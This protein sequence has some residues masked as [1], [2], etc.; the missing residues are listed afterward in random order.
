M[1]RRMHLIEDSNQ[2]QQKR[3]EEFYKKVQNVP[4]QDE[5]YM[6]LYQHWADQAFSNLFAVIA[7]QKLK[8]FQ[9]PVH[10]EFGECSSQAKTVPMHA[11]CLSDLMNGKFDG[12][13]FY[14]AAA[15]KAMRFDKYR[16]KKRGEFRRRHQIK[17]Q[18][19]K[20][21]QNDAW[22]GSFRM[23]MDMPPIP[24]T[25][26]N[27]DGD[28]FLRGTH[29]HHDQ[30]DA[31]RR[32]RRQTGIV[33]KNYY[34]LLTPSQGRLSPL[35]RIAQTMMKQVLKAKGKAEKD[36]VP[37]QNTVQRI[38]NSA[39]KRK[40][41]KKR[42]EEGELESMDQLTY[43]GLKRHGAI[44]EEDDLYE[45]AENPEKLGKF[46]SK[47][48]TKKGKLPIE[49]FVNMLRDGIKLGYAF[50]GQNATE[51]ENK[52]LKMVSPRFLSVT[53]ED[54]ND[55]NQNRTIDF[56]SPSLFSLHNHGKGIENL[57]SLPN[58]IK[59]VG[60]PLGFS[61]QDQ[62]L[63]LNFIME[64]SG[65]IE[66]T[67]KIEK[68][69]NDTAQPRGEALKATWSKHF[70]KDKYEREIRT[71]DGTPLYFTRQ[72]VSD[73]FG[74][75]EASKMDLFGTLQKD[76]NK[77]QI[78]DL[79]TTG[80]ALLTKK[81]LDLIYG[82]NSPYNDSEVL[83]RFTSMNKSTLLKHIENDI[84]TIA[85]IKSFKITP[86]YP[87]SSPQH[88]SKRQ[89][90]VLAPIVFQAFVN[91][92]LLAR[93]IILS[94]ILFSSLILAPSVFGPVILSP[95]AFVP[96]VLAPRLMSP[97]V[98][99]PVIFAP[100]ILTPLALH[101]IILSPGAFVPFVLSPAVL[102][103]FILSPQVFTPLILSPLA[104][105]PFILSPAAASPLVLSPFVLSPII[106]SPQ[107]LSAL[108][109]SPYALSPVINS[110]LIAYSVILSPSWLS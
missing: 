15:Q 79:N 47:T 1:K 56:L 97:L 38:Q 50:A 5:H 28:V 49:R 89:A 24:S 2:Q 104:L 45:I 36:V 31:H 42:L 110:P 108:V 41:M 81:Q 74:D 60:G 96:L 19:Q 103:P 63:W 30:Y 21:Q 44:A 13:K 20:Q 82:P 105:S 52:T 4:I 69:L 73:A 40:A 101:P 68:E 85:T 86:K 27:N 66:N 78:R 88:R 107:F 33:K 90:V 62:Q 87:P 59:S 32:E 18:R 10:D 23:M 58:L 57:T 39:N 7:N 64:A 35:G 109:L 11:K 99:S 55:G 14:K 95:W 53:A 91:V 80:F 48:R 72:N 76:I 6:Q 25:E 94:P 51:L 102:S 22:V 17:Q 98:L 84:H 83:H 43:R 3:R 16:M 61:S 70:D 12:E 37:W 71:E 93:P 77:N 75:V 92:F 67:E 46:L 100:V 54:E 34:E 65:V 9:K 8:Q 106:C 26:N 29:H